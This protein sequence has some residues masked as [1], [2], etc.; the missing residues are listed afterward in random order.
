MMASFL[1]ELR[2]VAIVNSLYCEM[3]T[4]AN[5][6]YC[7][8]LAVANSLYWEMLMVEEEQTCTP[9]LKKS[10]CFFSP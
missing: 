1:P 8:I 2:T 4:V 9:Y 10:L 6:P 5:N 7:E 3:L